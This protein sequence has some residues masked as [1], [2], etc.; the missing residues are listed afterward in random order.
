M[1]H[2]MFDRDSAATVVRVCG[3][4]F[5]ANASSCHDAQLHLDAGG[6]LTLHEKPAQEPAVLDARALQWR[7]GVGQTPL[8]VELPDGRVFE[9]QAFAAADQLRKRLHRRAPRRWLHRLE[10]ARGRHL[11]GAFFLIMGLAAASIYWGLPWLADKSARFVPMAW[12]ERMGV[13][14]LEM[15]D[16]TLLDG[17]TLPENTQQEIQAV[18]NDLLTRQPAPDYQFQ[19]YVRHSARLG[20]NALALP[21]GLVV[22]TDD[23]IKLARNNDEIA[24]VLAH[25]LGHAHHRHGLRSLARASSLS[26]VLLFVLGDG[27]S[28]LNDA[29]TFGAL[30]LQLSYSRTFEREADAHAVSLMHAVGRN[31]LALADMLE[32]LHAAH[33][34]DASKSSVEEETVASWLSTHPATGERI[35]A[36]HAQTAGMRR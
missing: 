20:A 35:H 25:E 27:A 23:L 5:A 34:H 31:P 30:F 22:I 19:L 4:V 28:L 7:E 10:R 9:T 36:I 12:E 2:R 14:V 24:A 18:F 6:R 15:L 21:G 16:A 8:R 3:R 29:A 17:S 1:A 11:I 26:F 33:P 32:R 13:G